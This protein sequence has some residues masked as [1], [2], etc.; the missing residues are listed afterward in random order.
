[1]LNMNNKTLAIILV[2]AVLVSITGTLVSLNKLQTV[3]L[4]GHVT[5]NDTGTASVTISRSV[6][7]RFAIDTIE[8]GS[9][10]VNAT[11]PCNLTINNSATITKAGGCNG[12]NATNAPR[13]DTF[14]LENAGTVNLNVTLNISKNSTSFIGGTYPAGPVFRYAISNNESGS[15]VGGGPAGVSGWTDVI[16]N[17][18]ITI[19]NN[20]S[21]TPTNNTLRMGLFL[22]IPANSIEGS[23]SVVI[24][25]QGTDLP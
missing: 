14:I 9:G 1:M 18:S 16:E 23:K 19:C 21:W 22:S 8:F 20:L 3:S 6:I 10:S 2:V 13:A 24:T 17:A 25:A 11:I 15:C 12:F 5:S 7:L 4:A